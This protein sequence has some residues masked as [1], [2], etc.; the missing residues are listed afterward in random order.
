MKRISS[1]FKSTWE[2]ALL[3]G[4]IILLVLAFRLTRSI[5]GLS[6]Q[7]ATE[8]PPPQQSPRA[9]PT[10]AIVP[11]TPRPT[12]GPFE[13]TQYALKVHLTPSSSEIAAYAT[14]LAEMATVNARLAL[15]TP[16][17]PPTPVYY[18][19]N[20]VADLPNVVL[21]DPFFGNVNNGDFGFCL[22]A[23]QPGEAVFVKSLD[24]EGGYYIVPFFNDKNVCALFIVT[25]ENGLG[26]AAAGG[27]GRG[28]KFPALNAEEAKALIEKD[29]GKMT[30]GEPLLAF[31]K[32][33]EIPDP[34]CPFW[35]I[36]T[37]DN[38]TYY[39]FGLISI[40]DDG[41]NTEKLITYVWNSSEVHP[42][43]P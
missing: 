33:R 16:P 18:P 31:R 3:G 10:E 34:F 30:I 21:N 39:V 23:N 42:I 29:T 32:I 28:S 20:S 12:L 7:A 8:Y 37:A 15:Y 1:F 38:Q 40:S 26:E 9:F 11:W 13:A 43:Y 27:Q 4:F 5:P 24:N 41:F 22:K 25:V 6:S 36:T 19:V 35:V 17:P 14:Y 2:F